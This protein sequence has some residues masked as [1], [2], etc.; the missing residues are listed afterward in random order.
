MHTFDVKSEKVE[1]FE[2]TFQTSL[3]YQNEL[4]EKQKMNNFHSLMSGYLLRT[5]KNITNPN[6]ENLGENLNVFSR[7]NVKQQSMAKAKHKF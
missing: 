7:K 4:T 2:V 1:L 5:F 3:K 6:R